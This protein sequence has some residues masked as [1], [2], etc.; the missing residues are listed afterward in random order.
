M[1]REIVGG[2]ALGD[3][4][5][6]DAEIAGLAPEWLR[7]RTALA[8]LVEKSPLYVRVGYSHWSCWYCNA[9]IN[10]PGQEGGHESECPWWRARQLLD[11]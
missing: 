10:N 4:A 1:A 2:H 3:E 11:E 9:H 7:V 6:I 5:A 8:A